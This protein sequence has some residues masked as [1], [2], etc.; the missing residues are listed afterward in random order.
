MNAVVDE[1]QE[2]KMPLLNNDMTLK[3]VDCN[4]AKKVLY[5]MPF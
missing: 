4:N 5:L 3:C 2:K 1:D